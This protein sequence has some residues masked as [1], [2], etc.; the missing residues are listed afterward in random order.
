MIKCPSCSAEL[1]F[2][3]NSQLVTCEY[4]GSKFNPK[5]LK[6][7]VKK[8]G[9]Q[10]ELDPNNAIEGK[11]YT[12]SQCGAK[13]LTFDETA[14]TFCSYCGS[15]AMIESKMMKT[16][17]PDYIIPFKKSKEECIKTYKKKWSKALFA[18]SYMKSDI[19]VSK[20]R[21]IYMPYCIYTLSKKGNVENKGS[22]FKKRRGDYDYYDD[23]RIDS[24]ID[25]EYSGI[26]YDLVAKF[27]DR[28]SQ[29][30]PFNHKEMEEFNPNYLSGFYADTKDVS[31]NIYDGE[32]TS[33]ARNDTTR[34]LRQ[35]KEFRK[36][37]CMNPVATLDIT[38]RKMG[39]FPVYFLAVRDKSEQKVHYA[40]VNGQTGKIAMDLPIDFKKYIIGSI[41]ITIPVF[42]LFEL[43]L[44]LVPKLVLGLAILASLVSMIISNSQLN[45]SYER[46]RHLDDRGYLI[47]ERKKLEKIA[48]EEIEEQPKKAKRKKKDKY[49]FKEKFA[50]YLYKQFIAIMICLLVLAI[51][52]VHDYYYYGGAIISLVIII[53]AFHDLVK[54]HNLLMSNKLPQLEKRGGDEHE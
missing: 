53:W 8:A 12:C 19:V 36:Y 34:F 16:N 18:P 52:P 48:E 17:K 31:N 25:A 3:V 44:Y 2:D 49:P 47:T 22:K 6:E 15:Q 7:T 30:I 39:M 11:S 4:C 1:K 42:I 24:D 13:L 9:E 23:Y 29:A 41:I 10:D 51:N 50:K 33:L 54:E 38:E 37:G 21:G 14:I 5:E 27:Y 28:Y 46:E 45:G 40:I 26:S 43:S 35:R 20:F 32:V